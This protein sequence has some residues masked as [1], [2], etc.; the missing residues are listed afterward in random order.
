MNKPSF[1]DNCNSLSKILLHN[2][3][4]KGHYCV[5]CS[6]DNI[7]SICIDNVVS[8]DDCLHVELSFKMKP[9]VMFYYFK[10][11]TTIAGKLLPM[12]SA[13]FYSENDVEKNIK[14]KYITLGLPEDMMGHTISQSTTII[15][16]I[17][18]P[19]QWLSAKLYFHAPKQSKSVFANEDTELLSKISKVGLRL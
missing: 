1:C 2:V 6:L 14:S 18:V 12:I 5:D 4:G 10:I 9:Y 13:R 19:E 8:G 17:P 7:I 16:K 3:D 11:N 15:Y